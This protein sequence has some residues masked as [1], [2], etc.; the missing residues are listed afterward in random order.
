MF[1]STKKVPPTESKKKGKEKK[2]ATV[3]KEEEGNPTCT[4]CQK[5]GHEEVKCWKLH[6][7]FKPKCFKDRKGKQ[8]PH[9]SFRILE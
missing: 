2:V 1:G 3:K 5:N 9:L 6:P 7:K 8:R 4:D